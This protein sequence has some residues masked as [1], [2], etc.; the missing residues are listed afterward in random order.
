MSQPQR[1]GPYYSII[2]VLGCIKIET[3]YIH[4]FQM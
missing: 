1:A 4:L 2:I 3:A